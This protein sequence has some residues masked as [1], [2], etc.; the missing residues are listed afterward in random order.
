MNSGRRQ[1]CFLA[2]AGV[3]PAWCSMPHWSSASGRPV[4]GAGHTGLSWHELSPRLLR[5]AYPLSAGALQAGK[6]SASL[7]SGAGN[8]GWQPV[9]W[10]KSSQETPPSAGR[11]PELVTVSVDEL[12]K[13]QNSGVRARQG[14]ALR[15]ELATCP[16]RIKGPLLLFSHSLP[17]GAASCL[18]P[19][20]SPTQG[21]LCRYRQERPGSHDHR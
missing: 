13:E 1:G 19:L 10:G 6:G 7:Q 18:P 21:G 9:G 5:A 3:P 2:V 20:Q 4:G 8:W 17:H 14:S 16:A 11:S 12:E 15:A